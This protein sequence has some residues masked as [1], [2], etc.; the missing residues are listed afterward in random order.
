MVKKRSAK[1]AK[2][3]SGRG[4]ASTKK[5][6]PE[7]K[8]KKSPPKSRAKQVAKPT[9]IVFDEWDSYVGLLDGATAF[10]SFD[11]LVTRGKPPAGLGLCARV[12]IPIHAPTEVGAPVSPETEQLWAMEDEL[13]SML[14]KHKVQCR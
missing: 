2:P 8:K 7:K 12:L 9:K 10:I 4:S 6:A 3:T 5:S 11:D 1:R 14:R 13:C